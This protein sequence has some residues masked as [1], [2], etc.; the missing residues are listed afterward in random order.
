[1]KEERPVLVVGHKNP[2]TDS[3][4]AAIAY[5]RLKNRISNERHEPR[6]AGHLN[7]ETRFVLK[8]F[9]V[10]APPLLSDVRMQVKDLEIRELEGAPASTSLKDAWEKMR[11]AGVVTLCV[12]E[13]ETLQG[14]ITTGDIVA[15]YMDVYE[16][17]ILADAKTPYENIL[18]TLD[19]EMIVG[20]AE[21]FVETGKVVVAA[22]SPEVMENIIGSGDVVI[23]GNRYETQLC[24][25]EM[26]AA[27]IIVCD[28]AE[29]ARTIRGQAEQHHCRIITT[30]H[31]TYTASRLVNTSLPISFFMRSEGLVAFS[32]DDYIDDIQEVM[33]QVRH[34]YFPVLG[35]NNTYVGMI[36]RRN[37][38]GARK[39]RLILVDHNEESQAVKGAEAAE[40][41]EII[42]HHR[43]GSIVTAA[44]VFFRNQPLGSTSTIV[45]LMYHE[46]GV[47]ID[48]QTAGLLLAAILSDTLM[49]RS[50]T[51]TPAD[52]A[53]GEALAAIAGVDA[54]KFAMEMFR[55]GSDMSA[56]T[57]QQIIQQDFKKFTA[58]GQTIGIGQINSMSEEELAEVREKILPEIEEVRRAEGLDMVFVLLTNIL[59]EESEVVFAGK[60]AGSIIENGFSVGSRN[61]CALLAGV[62]SRK[63][64]FLPT[65]V[66]TME[67]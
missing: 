43:L 6:R 2:D 48:P 18:K 52:R 9:G 61:G 26:G 14:I 66:D 30:P 40:I 13:G 54:E 63:K 55:A 62:V 1:M 32:P 57:P 16:S 24:A 3:V 11:N 67:S 27:C 25:L 5:A 42:D 65:I 64:Q 38:L 46:N 34:R 49:Y 33:A 60:A 35:E 29:V 50:P 51:C 36:S 22:A 20:S 58:D 12:T 53:A 59:K 10:E 4:C 17:D 8:R 19:G 37:F 31:D 15:S 23:L 41:L 44:P 47:E 28:G 56:K 45:Y 39:K 7:E 21:G